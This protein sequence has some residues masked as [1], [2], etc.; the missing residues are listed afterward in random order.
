MHID[1]CT[2]PSSPHRPAAATT[3]GRG[4]PAFITLSSDEDEP[5]HARPLRAPLSTSAGSNGTGL[6]DKALG[7]RKAETAPPKVEK[8]NFPYGDL[9]P[10][11]E[12]KIRIVFASDPLVQNNPELMKAAQWQEELEGS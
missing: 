12:K 8:V 2:P 3:T 11:F 5:P 1:L 9:A 10:Q 6:S 7:K 4:A